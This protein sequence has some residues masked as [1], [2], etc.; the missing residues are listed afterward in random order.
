MVYFIDLISKKSIERKTK[1][2]HGYIRLKAEYLKTVLHNYNYQIDFLLSK[3]IISRIPYSKGKK[4]SFGYKINVPDESLKAKKFRVYDFNSFTLRKKLNLKQI[5]SKK[6]ADS[7]TSHITK[8]LRN[9]ITFDYENAVKYLNSKTMEDAKLYHRL[10]CCEVLKQGVINYS[11]EGKD[12]RLHSTFTSLPSELRQFLKFKSNKNE[13]V[14]LDIKSSQP[15][16]LAGIINLI[17]LEDYKRIEYLSNFIK[18]SR[19]RNKFLSSLSV[20]IPKMTIEPAIIEL[21]EFI[22]IVTNKDLY[23]YI[24]SNFSSEHLKKIE[25]GK[26]FKDK[27]YNPST[28]KKSIKS[29]NSLRAY[30]KL[31]MLEYMYCSSKS[32]EMRYLEIRRILPNVLNEF[33][34]TLKEVNTGLKDSKNDFPIIL[35]NIEAGLFLDVL[36]KEFHEKHIDTPFITVH[37]SIMVD[38]SKKEIAYEMFTNGYNNIFGITPVLG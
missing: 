6:N 17:L 30:C 14:S 4:E 25:S 3:G 22:S 20:M 29:F 7:T 28:R 10:Y 34:D 18:L 27:F 5:S 11:R 1:L 26:S 19:L 33:I 12:N 23:E 35:Q 16:H 32:K 9:N 2:V 13:L 38:K 21:K 8:W 36:C 31:A 15:F 37:D 24:G